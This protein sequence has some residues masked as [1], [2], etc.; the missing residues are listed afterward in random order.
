[1]WTVTYNKLL[2][3]YFKPKKAESPCSKCLFFFQV[4]LQTLLWT[5][6]SQTQ[7]RNF[8]KKCSR[9]SLKDNS[10]WYAQVDWVQRKSER[11]VSCADFWIIHIINKKHSYLTS[12]FAYY[13]FVFLTKFFLPEV[14][15]SVII[16]HIT[17]KDVTKISETHCWT[18]GERKGVFWDIIL[19]IFF[20]NSTTFISWS[21]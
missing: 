8:F 3:F 21:G 12:S 9:A 17:S 15:L 18:L 10:N 1:M 20:L 14:V 2:L 7:W 19:Y 13:Q 16:K 6:V 5:Y 4:L 11:K